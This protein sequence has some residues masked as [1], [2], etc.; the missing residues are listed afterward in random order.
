[1]VGIK[2]E[3]ENEESEDESDRQQEGK[4]VKVEYAHENNVILISYH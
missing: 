4:N 1:M 2:A 3:E